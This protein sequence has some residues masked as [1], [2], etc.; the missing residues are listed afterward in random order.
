MTNY[1]LVKQAGIIRYSPR[2]LFPDCGN[3]INFSIKM[4]IVEE[5]SACLKKM[6]KRIKV[7]Y[8]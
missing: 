7:S 8:F 6:G 4:N 5:L 3:P 1:P 2:F